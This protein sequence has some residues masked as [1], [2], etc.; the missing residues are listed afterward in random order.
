MDLSADEA[1]KD[2]KATER[3]VEKLFEKKI[4]KCPS[5][6]EYSIIYGEE[7]H[8]RLPKLVCSLAESRDHKE[9]P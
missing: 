5:G 8:P 9:A 6:G 7:P 1:W 2:P 3:L 4:P